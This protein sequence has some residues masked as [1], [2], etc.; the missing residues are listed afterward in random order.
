MHCE[1]R[2]KT[3]F[4]KVSYK[5]SQGLYSAALLCGAG[6][7][8]QEEVVYVFLSAVTKSSFTFLWSIFKIA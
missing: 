6:Q 1:T 7:G 8:E 5:M 3:T 2:E 4:C